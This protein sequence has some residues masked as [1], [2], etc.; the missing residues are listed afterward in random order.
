MHTTC[1]AVNSNDHERW[2][3]KKWSHS[4]PPRETLFGF[5][6][7]LSIGAFLILLCAPVCALGQDV[8]E[9]S[10]VFGKRF[11]C[12]IS[13]KAIEKTPKWRTDSETPPLAVRKAIRAAER[14]A[15]KFVKAPPAFKR[16]IPQID[17]VPFDDNWWYWM[18]VFEWHAKV[19][20]ESDG[21][22]Y[23]AVPVL[24]DGT[25]IEPTV[26]LRRPRSPL[27]DSC[28]AWRRR[29]L[30]L[31]SPILFC[32]AVSE[33][34]EERHLNDDVAFAKEYTFAV[35]EKVIK[36][37]PRWPPD[38][39]NPPLAPRA[40]VRAAE[41]IASRFVVAD[42]PFQRRIATISLLPLEEDRWYWSVGFE[43]RPTGVVG[44]TGIPNHLD[45][46]VLMD[47]T[48]VQPTVK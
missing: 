45:V 42:P 33:R 39:E 12:A 31:P 43:W 29:C 27:T 26:E 41:R 44:G 5:R 30:G 48:A 10:Y 25:A 6:A 22:D 13:G 11:E 20:D 3:R 32:T 1:S 7:R 36:R 21:F 19:G 17:L 37:S 15:S 18:I 40:A 9:I 23:L 35:L 38:S 4:R 24:M 28:P 2:G 8:G 16:I 47:G 46:P 14:V 34:S